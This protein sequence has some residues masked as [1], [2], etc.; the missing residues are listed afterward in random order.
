MYVVIM[1]GSNVLIS[2]APNTNYAVM[3]KGICYRGYVKYIVC[4]IL[5]N[6]DL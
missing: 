5:F 6:R 3:A 4:L 2:A 1:G